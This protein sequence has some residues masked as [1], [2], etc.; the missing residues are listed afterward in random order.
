MTKAIDIEFLGA[1]DH[2]ATT[3]LLFSLS[4]R[5]SSASRRCFHRSVFSFRL[6]VPSCRSALFHRIFVGLMDPTFLN[7]THNVISIRS[8][9]STIMTRLRKPAFCLFGSPP[10]R[11]KEHLYNGS[12]NLVPMGLIFTLVKLGLN[13]SER[14]S[15]SA[16]TTATAKERKHGI[17]T[18]T[19]LVKQRL[20]L[21]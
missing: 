16:I 8:P 3:Q 20:T 14:A 15:P 9:I 1:T 10:V 6:V 12:F 4:S 17:A 5:L 7:P 2:A 18:P 11:D 19:A 13:M 21:Y